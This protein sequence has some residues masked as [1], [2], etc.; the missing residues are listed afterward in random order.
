MTIDSIKIALSKVTEGVGCLCGLPFCGRC[1]DE[2]FFKSNS[3]SYVQ[4]LLDEVDRLQ[5]ELKAQ[6]VGCR[7]NAALCEDCK[8]N[9]K[10]LT[11]SNEK[12]RKALAYYQ[13]H[14]IGYEFNPCVAKEALEQSEKPKEKM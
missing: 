13:S 4:F 8:V 12:M 1:R 7:S 14:P 6:C 9:F 2:S 3:K 10:S 5:T 11:L